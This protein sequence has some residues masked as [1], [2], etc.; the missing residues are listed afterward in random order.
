[1]IN[2]PAI[3]STIR[4]IPPKIMAMVPV[5][6][7]VIPGD[8]SVLS[9]LSTDPITP[10]KMEKAKIYLMDTPLT[11]RVINV[12]NCVP[13]EEPSIARKAAKM[14]TFPLM[15]CLIVAKEAEKTI[16]NISVPTA[17]KDGSPIT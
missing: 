8:N 10:N 5:S 2:N 3:M 6:S 1:M 17:I 13:T 12:P 4:T 14:I 16:W 9:S 15:V 11:Y 7:Q